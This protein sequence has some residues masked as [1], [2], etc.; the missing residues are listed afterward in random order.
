[1]NNNEELKQQL[2]SVFNEDLQGMVQRLK[3]L[4]QLELKYGNASTK[5]FISSIPAYWFFQEANYCYL[6]GN[7]IATIIIVQAALEQRL[8]SFFHASRYA[9]KHGLDLNKITFFQLIEEAIKARL[10]TK[11]EGA[12][13][14]YLRKNI[15]NQYTHPKDKEVSTKLKVDNQ[16][17]EHTLPQWYVLNLKIQGIFVTQNTKK[18]AK[19]AL[20]IL[21]ESYYSISFRSPVA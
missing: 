20:K 8:R 7:F 16:I 3:F 19:K 5:D 14:H 13:L 10:I 2:I 12:S 17:K 9:D 21:Y 4:N 1:M 18:E 15:R 6:Y 11:K